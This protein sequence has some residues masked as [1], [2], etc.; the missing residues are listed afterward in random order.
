M[1]IEQFRFGYRDPVKFQRPD[2]IHHK[3][4]RQLVNI[5]EHPEKWTTH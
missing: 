4:I 1:K 2:N 3:T 5:A